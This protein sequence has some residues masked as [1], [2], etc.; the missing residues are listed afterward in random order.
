[1]A[2]KK[3]IAIVDGIRTPF[4]KAN[5]IL[6]AMEADDLGAYAV[7][8]LIARTNIDPNE[9]DEL[10]FGNVLQPPHATNIARVISVKGGLPVTVPAFTVNRNCSSGMEAVV[11]AANKIELDQADVIIAGG[12]ESMSNF[13]ILV[14][15]AMKEWLTN[16]SK[17][18]SF[19]AKLKMLGQ[20][21][22][23]HFKPEIP[24]I[25]DP[26]CGLTMGDTAE[27]LSK[28]FKVT[29]KEQDLFAFKSQE[30]AAAARRSGVLA[31]EI[32][33]IPMPTKYETMI[34]Q[35]DGIRDDQKLSD[36]EKLKPV[37]NTISGTVTAGTSS[38]I[39]DGAVALLLM[40]EE[41]CKELGYKPLGYILDYSWAALD[42]SRMGLGPAYAISKILDS[43]GL[44]LDQ[45][46]LIEINEAFAS[47]VL[48]VQKALASD[49]FAKK[50]L[51]KNKAI[52][53]LDME[54]LN[55]NGGAL[56]IGH[57]LGASGAR[58]ILTILK[59]LKRRNKKIGLASLCVG[60]GQGEAIIV[61][62]AS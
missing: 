59:E 45:F 4:I 2:L 6:K 60:G 30:K 28:D 10:I 51:G 58:L 26:L 36:L 39:T 20:L 16:L 35:D 34:E 42:P 11:A 46:D 48:A 17:A 8:E 43:S 13:P 55:V 27:I 12:V 50:E 29:R 62:A 15:K 40:S 5:G 25:S 54:K 18:K 49:E 47:Q 9:V 56:A 53:T 44:T 14:S 33:P 24:K 31:E 37:F 52:G 57:P 19:W 23:A 61:E 32:V 1:M 41:K 7:K 21:R 3:R 22:A 38:P